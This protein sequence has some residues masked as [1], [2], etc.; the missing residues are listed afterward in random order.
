MKA[1]NKNN[2]EENQNSKY[3]NHPNKYQLIHQCYTLMNKWISYDPHR[4]IECHFNRI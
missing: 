1:N 3:K 2:Q 4:N